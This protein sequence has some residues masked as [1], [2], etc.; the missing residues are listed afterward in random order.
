MAGAA[1]GGSYTQ[2]I[3]F[4]SSGSDYG[5]QDVEESSSDDEDGAASGVAPPAPVAAGSQGH[6]AAAGGAADSLTA[7]AAMES[8]TA[9]L[10]S[11][12]GQT[13]NLPAGGGSAAPAVAQQVAAPAAD[14]AAGEVSRL[15]LDA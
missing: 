12:E 9:A 13:E 7:G 1:A 2:D 5:S 14:S 10:K 8:P 15:T 6:E 11:F 4:P 3:D